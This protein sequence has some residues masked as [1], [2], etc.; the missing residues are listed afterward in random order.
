[1]AASIIVDGLNS[2][3]VQHMISRY[4]GERG[5][6]RSVATAD[7]C[8]GAHNCLP[9]ALQISYSNEIHRVHSTSS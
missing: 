7:S 3:C 4:F 5:P 9:G 2:V 1:M 8:I 6:A